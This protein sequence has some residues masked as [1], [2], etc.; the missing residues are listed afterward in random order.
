MIDNIYVLYGG[1][2]VEHEIS[3][4]SARAVLNALD[5]DKYNIIP[6]FI[7]KNGSWQ[8]L[9]PLKGSIEKEEDLIKSQNLGPAKSLGNFLAQDYKSEESNFF[10]PILHGTNGEDGV[11][12]GLFELIDVPYMGN[13]LLSSAICMDKI[14][15]NQLFDAYKI[16]QAAY[17]GVSE[18]DYRTDKA[19]IIEDIEKIGYPVFV[20]PANAGSS[21]GVSKAD[22]R[23]EL[24]QSLE[25]AFKYDPRVVVEDSV[26][27]RE[28][29]IA[30]MGN[31]S[32]VSS[33]PGEHVVNTQEFF[34]YESKYEDKTTVIK[35]PTEVEPNQEDEARKLAVRAYKAMGCSGLARV[36]IFLR[37]DGSLALNE[38][39]TLPGMTEIS[40]FPMLWK[41]SAGKDLSQVIEDLIQL[42]L[43]N[44]RDKKE[45]KRSYK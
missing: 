17:V 8:A 13:G 20:K 28:L 18:A 45:K 5:K 11:V 27:G 12:Q 9:D 35:A 15:A 43:D 42:G 30:V 29:E 6:V 16:P 4:R 7:D 3:L 25:K 1:V 19:S 36:D 23:K 34:D 38:I 31:H 10:M 22:D 44:Y 41:P 2:S 33:L 21:V 39:N 14:V 37:S 24:E 32:P 40:L 26:E